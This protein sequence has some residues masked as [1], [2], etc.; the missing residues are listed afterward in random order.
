M[1]KSTPLKHLAVG[2]SIALVSWPMADALIEVGEMKLPYVLIFGLLSGVYSALAARRER[3]WGVRLVAIHALL[4]LA[5]AWLSLHLS[6]LFDIRDYDVLLRAVDQ[7][8][9]VRALGMEFVLAAL[10]GGWLVLPAAL[11]MVQLVSAR[12]GGNGP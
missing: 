3:S 11:W 5:L 7:L 12:V 9:V 4:G 2:L 1:S 8:G 10:L 6:R